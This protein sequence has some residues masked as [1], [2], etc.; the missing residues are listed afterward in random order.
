MSAH[1]LMTLF[2]RTSLNVYDADIFNCSRQTRERSLMGYAASRIRAIREN[3]G[4][5]VVL[6]VYINPFLLKWE[7]DAANCGVSG[8]RWIFNLCG[9]SLTRPGPEA[10]ILPYSRAC[11]RR[12]SGRHFRR[13][14]RVGSIRAEVLCCNLGDPL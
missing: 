8:G 13:L 1:N 9:V 2:K 11:D 6:M 14:T 12:C 5:G 10:I 7:T 3:T 4:Y